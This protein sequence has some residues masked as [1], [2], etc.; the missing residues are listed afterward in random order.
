MSALLPE[1]CPER[2]TKVAGRFGGAFAHRFRLPFGFRRFAHRSTSGRFQTRVARRRAI[3]LGK[4]GSPVKRIAFRRVVRRTSATSARPRR[5]LP[6]AAIPSKMVSQ[7]QCPA[8]LRRPGARHR[9]SSLRRVSQAIAAI[10]AHWH[11][12]SEPRPEEV[13]DGQD[14]A[15]EYAG[16]LQAGWPLCDRLAAPRSTAQVL[17]PHNHRSPGGQGPTRSPVIGARCRASLLRSTRRAGSTP[18]ADEHRG[19]S[20]NARGAPTGAI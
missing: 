17:P 6:S 2:G 13:P 14:G 4:S 10:L 7:M 20:L 5:F 12:P 11:A 16:H 15:N 19:G 8:P 1:L 18:T 9:R 3:G